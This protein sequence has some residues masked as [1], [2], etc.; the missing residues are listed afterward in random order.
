MDEYRTLVVIYRISADLRNEFM[1]LEMEKSLQNGEVKTE[2][3]H[4]IKIKLTVIFFSQR[5]KKM[6]NHNIRYVQ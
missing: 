5:I 3:S 6:L 2:W 4:F 1:I